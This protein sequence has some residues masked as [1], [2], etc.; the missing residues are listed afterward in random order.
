M[1]KKLEPRKGSA[2][3]TNEK[4]EATTSELHKVESRY[5]DEKVSF[6]IKLPQHVYDRL[7]EEKRRTGVSCAGIIL[8]VLDE[9][10]KG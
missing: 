7:M 3:R 1:T 6:S 8:R 2:V 5:S 10:F 4:I 9:Y